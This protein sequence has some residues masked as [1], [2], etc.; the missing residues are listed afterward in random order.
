LISCRRYI[1]ALMLLVAIYSQPVLTAQC[2]LLCNTDF[3]NQQVT[4]SVAILD[5]SHVPCWNTTAPDN[6]I[7]VWH[8][9][10]NGVPS[11]SGLQ[12]IELN[13]YYVSTLYQNFTATPGTAISVSF[14]HRAGQAPIP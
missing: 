11:Y 9:G 1:Q 8:T 12:F 13:A 10:F 4:N 14:A 6:N 7:E 5:A 2:S 3:E